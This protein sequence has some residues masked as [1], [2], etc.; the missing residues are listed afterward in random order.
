MLLITSTLLILSY[1]L[2]AIDKIPK[3]TV[4]M[5]AACL[6]IILTH[7]KAEMVF[8][9]I[10]FNV[11]FLLIGMMIIVN[12]TN[13][14]GIF[15]WLAIELLKRTGGK[16][17]LVFVLLCTFT[18]VAS[19][20]LDNVTT[21]IIMMPITFSICKELELNPVPF[22]L[23]Q[24][25]ASNIGGTATLIG[26][27][28]NIIIGSAAGLSFMDF[29]HELTP[30]IT[31]IFIVCTAVLTFW[32]RKEL[33]VQPHVHAGIMEIDNTKTIHNKKMLGICLMVLLSVITG[34]ILHGTLHLEAYVIA[35]SGASFLLL[36]EK[37]NNI[38]HEVEWS[39]IFFF[40]G[41]F[42]VIGGFAQ[43]GGI[44]FMAQK[45]L[46]L[47]QGNL[48]YTSYFVL[49]VSGILSA[50]VDN[51]PY[52][53]TITPMI[54]ELKTAMDITP[55]WWALSLGACLGGNATMI[56]AAA[57]VIV[58]EESHKHGYKIS[59]M[60]FMKYGTTITLISLIISSVYLYVRF[61]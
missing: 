35:L 52:T 47:T 26:D 45:V 18:A 25:F 50:L 44:R 60:Q 41:L 55:L 40:I 27:P 22:L 46:E 37:P 53:A 23:A 24:V 14:T 29:V 36:F 43:A 28:P 34:F 4:V 61:L 10:D 12:I 39:T 19:A 38:L 21:V 57:N 6:T 49:W 33:V 16:P 8:S 2:I 30:V 31:I 20:F 13:R 1:V 7:H 58:C 5:I 51:I 17:K 32:F 9:F 42:I 54:K 11:I 15:R 48:A 56:G 59:F 3:V